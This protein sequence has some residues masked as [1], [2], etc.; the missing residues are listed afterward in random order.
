M[1]VRPVEPERCAPVV[2]HQ[3]DVAVETQLLPEREEEIALLHVSIAVRARIR[4]LVG[5][6]HADQIARDQ[7]AEADA[8]RHDLAPEV[9]AGRVAM[10]EDDRRAFALVEVGHP[11]ALDLDELLLSESAVDHANLQG[12]TA[13]SAA[14]VY[15][16]LAG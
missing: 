8:G 13:P 2:D 5:V 1:L 6:A 14:R 15:E 12:D 7:A 3:D 16:R 9:R 11:A 10:L 4:E